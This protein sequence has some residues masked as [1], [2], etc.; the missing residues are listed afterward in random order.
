MFRRA[1]NV[2]TVFVARVRS[3]DDRFV[4]L[5]G[6]LVSVHS[7]YRV[8]VSAVAAGSL[9][10]HRSTNDGTHFRVGPNRITGMLS[11]IEAPTKNNQVMKK[12]YCQ[13]YA[14][15]LNKVDEPKKTRATYILGA[16]VT[17][18]RRSRATHVGTSLD[19]FVSVRR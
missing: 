17:A 6:L 18:L 13:S 16:N 12:S 9:H 1:Y 10:P 2:W 4:R 5:K 11:P 15:V 19:R 14:P 3:C 8:Q 7:I